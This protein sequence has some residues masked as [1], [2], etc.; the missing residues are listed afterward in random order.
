MLAKSFN[1]KTFPPE[2]FLEIYKHIKHPISLILVNK[3]FHQLCINPV[4][5]SVWALANFGRIHVLF[6]AISL[7]KTFITVDVIKSL[8]ALKVNLSRY[9]IQRLLL[10]YGQYDEELTKID[11]DKFKAFQKSMKTPWASDI[12]YDVFTALLDEAKEIF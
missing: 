6:Y 8:L 2:L 12:P 4:A 7:G 9:F 10:Q 3:K 11:E 5:K 1:M